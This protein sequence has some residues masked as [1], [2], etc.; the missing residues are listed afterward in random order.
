MKVLFL[1]IAYPDVSVNTNMYTD[2]VDEFL[3]YGHE[4]YVAA[5]GKSLTR[6]KIEGGIKVLRIKTLPLFKT[7]MIIKGIANIIL[8]FQYKNAI[9]R[10]LCD[11]NFDL[12]ITPT[13]PITFNGVAIML[14]KKSQSKIYLILR[15]IFPQ[16]ARD[17]GLMRSSLLFS[18]FRRKEKK[19][20]QIA[21]S[22]GC[23]SPKNIEFIHKHNPEVNLEKLHLLPNW[24]KISD[25]SASFSKLKFNFGNK[26]VAVFGGNFGVPQKIEFLIEV[27]EKL[28]EKSDILFYM[29]GDG[30]ELHKIK[31]LVK[32]KDLRNVIIVDQLPREDYSELLKEC[33]VGLV[34]L[35]DKFTIPNIPSRTLS[36]WSHKLPVLAAVDRST[37]YGKLLEECNG[38]LWSITGDTG[39]YIFNLMSLYNDPVKR[40]Q[41]GE[42]GYN[43]VVNN[44]NSESAYTQILSKI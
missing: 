9:K 42:N 37:D 43:H 4:V 16:N 34:N 17:L 35:S 29:V 44:L 5:P 26:F 23:M 39:S 6:V 33:H 19:L 27:A 18:Y 14:K 2:L 31:K 21:D 38:G 11:I 10:H 3:K 32:D 25:R 12:V 20:Y 22:I 15:D 40:R 30:T 7:S 24:T 13:P 36:Y 1:M 28:K 8:P 41:M